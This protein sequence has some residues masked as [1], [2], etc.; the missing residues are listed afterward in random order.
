MN[1]ERYTL[2]DLVGALREPRR[3]YRESRRL[4]VE[5]LKRTSARHFEWTHGEGVD[6]MDEDWDNLFILDACRYDRFLERN[7]IDGD[8][9]PVLS[10][11]GHSRLFMEENFVGRELH[12]TVYVTAN[13]HA[14][15]LDQDTF[16]TVEMIPYSDRNPER[17]A[18][19]ALELHEEYPDKRLIVHFMQPHKPYLGP[20]GER[21]RERLRDE[22]MDH[23]IE[24]GNY[25]KWDAVREGAM[26]HEELERAYAENVDIGLSSV[27]D[28]LGSIGGK[29]V[30]TSDHGELLGET[31]YSVLGPLYGHPEDVWMEPLLTVPWLVVDADE[32]REVVAERPLG[33]EKLDSELAK[34]RLK[35]LGYVQ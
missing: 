28:L 4:G 9:R 31:L 6:V 19:A 16:Y 7:T 20:T 17:V 26:S 29:S 3:L 2:G 22:G 14:D 12:D 18:E 8:L 13:L 34:D 33:F 1:L 27:E 30:V 25:I 35:E 11:G 5:L 23:L 24:R 15:F 32:R 10:K 21:V